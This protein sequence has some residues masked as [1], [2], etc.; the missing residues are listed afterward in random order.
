MA[1]EPAGA[2]TDPLAERVTGIERE[3][4]RQ[5]G[6]LDRILDR[7]GGGS[8]ETTPVTRGTEPQP[9]AAD[10]AEQM[11][12]AVRDV[13]AEAAAGAAAKAPDPEAAP[14]EVMIKG[15]ERIQRAIFGSDPRR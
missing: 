12:Q 14:A 1:D 3:Q 9:S 7:L 2:G 6:L 15:K 10:M 13:Q 8:D 11:R 4:D 5:G